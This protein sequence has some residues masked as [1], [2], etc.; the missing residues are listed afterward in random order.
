MWVLNS[1][2]LKKIA[3]ASSALD[4]FGKVSGIQDLHFQPWYV[5]CDVIPLL[6]YGS[7]TISR[8]D[9]SRLDA[10]GTKCLRSI[11]TILMV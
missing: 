3:I 2:N 10:F 6:V 5:F 11:C 1:V 7:E 9:H 4:L 8:K